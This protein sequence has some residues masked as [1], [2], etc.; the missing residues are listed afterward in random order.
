MPNS[1]RFPGCQWLLSLLVGGLF[2]AVYQGTVHFSDWCYLG[3]ST[4]VAAGVSLILVPLNKLLLRRLA[5]Q[6]P[7]WSAPGRWAWLSGG[8]LGLFGLANGLVWPLLTWLG[9]GAA[10]PWGMAAMLVAVI[11]NQK[12]LILASPGT[13]QPSQTGTPH[14]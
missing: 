8:I 11:Y 10:G 2:Y 9:P 5:S 13:T 12:L 3:V 4:A 7:Q 1:T 14:H 6:G